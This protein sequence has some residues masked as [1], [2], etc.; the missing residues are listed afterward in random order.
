VG[1]ASSDVERLELKPPVQARS[2]ATLERILDATEILAQHRWFHVLTVDEI[3]RAAGVSVGSFYA[4]FPHKEA[5]LSTL[6]SRYREQIQTLFDDEFTRQYRT[7]DLAARVFGFAQVYV[8]RVRR[9]RG[10]IRALSMQ[11]RLQPGAMS[12]DAAELAELVTDRITEF[13][14]ERRS[15]MRHPDPV[16]A[17]RFGFFA[18]AATVREKVIYSEAPHALIVTASDTQLAQEL[19]QM[20]FAYLTS[21]SEGA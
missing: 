1:V 9:I 6:H 21:R 16:G 3:V 2:R 10:L 17:I 11:A 20:L 19:A 14:L 13:L 12:L 18:L 15:E 4:R 5:L 7:A 8:A